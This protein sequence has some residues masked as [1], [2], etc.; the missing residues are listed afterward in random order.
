M[1]HGQGSNL[2]KLIKWPQG[3]HRFQEQNN[4]ILRVVPPLFG[5]NSKLYNSPM[6]LSFHDDQSLS[7]RYTRR[8]MIPHQPTQGH[9]APAFLLPRRAMTKIYFN[10][11]KVLPRLE[12]GLLDS[13]SRVITNYTTKPCTEYGGRTHDLGV[14]ST[15]L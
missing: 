8:Y 9:A 7:L 1:C 15:S 12:L 14:I 2:R 6:R 4:Y 13:K 3:A 11:T 10:S 5:T